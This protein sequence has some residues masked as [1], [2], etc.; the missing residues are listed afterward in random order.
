M[1]CPDR[2]ASP[3]PTDPRRRR[4]V[5][6]G[7]LAAGGLTGAV[8]AAGD[9]RLEL[10]AFELQRPDDGLLLSYGVALALP[11]AV[12]DALLKGVPL[13]F[14]VEVEVHRERWYW[15]DL[16]VA[17]QRRE[18]RLAWQ[19]LTRR[20]RLS[21]GGFTQQHERLEDAL[22]VIAAASRWQ[23][24]EPGTLD[25]EA[26]HRVSFSFRLDSSRLPRPLQFSAGTTDAWSLELER[27]AI[28]LPRRA[29]PG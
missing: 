26:S 24:A 5:Q 17:R 25:P 28:L 3:D 11:D 1:P 14:V 18:W 16:R 2:A 4:L 12:E 27:S 23:V 7:L 19:P 9:G 13:H 21:L 15:R 6:A 29:G 22:A 20:H 8:R 10:S